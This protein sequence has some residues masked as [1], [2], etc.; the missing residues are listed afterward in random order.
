[1]GFWQW[2]IKIWP[3][4]RQEF[5]ARWIGCEELQEGVY[6]DPLKNRDNKH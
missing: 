5:V 3:V 2:T 1:M 4:D 6:A